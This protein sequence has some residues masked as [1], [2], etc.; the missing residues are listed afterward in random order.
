VPG[1]SEVYKLFSDRVIPPIGKAVTGDAQPYQYLVESIRKF[2]PPERFSA[3]IAAG[4]Q[5]RDAHAFRQYRGA[6]RQHRG[7]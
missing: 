5:A 6:A 7:D 1:S 3:M 2:P 4:L